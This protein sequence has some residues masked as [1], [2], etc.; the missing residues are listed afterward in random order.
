MH[1]PENIKTILETATCLHPQTAVETAFD[2]MAKHINETL[3]ETN[4]IFL[5]VLIGGIIPLGY[6]LPRLNFPL[7]VDYIH[8]S[9]YEGKTTGG[10]LSWHAQP[11]KSLKDRTIIL[12]D[13]ILDTGI[14]LKAL[15]DFCWAEGAKAVYTAVLVDKQHARTAEGL[16]TADFVGLSVENRYVF[17]YGLDYKE[18]LRNARGIFAVQKEFE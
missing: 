2:E 8:A 14:T 12:V 1:L 13:D 18:Y 7:E 6:L 11:R 9:R 15:V 3:A 4:P 10:E 16:Q 5:C 17:G